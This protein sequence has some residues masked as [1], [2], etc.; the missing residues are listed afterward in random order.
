MGVLVTTTFGLLV[1][2]V[3]WSMGVKGFDGFMLTLTL[4][5]VA[6]MGRV[7]MSSRARD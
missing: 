5:V 6:A 2:V 7:V 1:W 3:L 4:I